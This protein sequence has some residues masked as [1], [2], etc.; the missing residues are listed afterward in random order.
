M[1]AIERADSTPRSVAGLSL[2]VWTDH[3]PG[4][5]RLAAVDRLIAI[6]AEAFWRSARRW[7]V[8]V[9]ADDVAQGIAERAVRDRRREMAGAL[10]RRW[11]VGDDVVEAGGALGRA[12]VDLIGT[13]DESEA[14]AVLVN[15]PG[16]SIDEVMA[17][18]SVLYRLEGPERAAQWLSS[19]P[20]GSAMIDALRASQSVLGELPNGR[21]ALKWMLAVHESPGGFTRWD[22]VLAGWPEEDRSGVRLRH[23]AALATLD[24]SWRF[25]DHDTLAEAVRRRLAGRPTALRGS[26]GEDFA[27]PVDEW[28]A[29]HAARLSRADLLGVWAVLDVLDEPTIVAA[30]FEQA[31]MDR[32]DTST[33]YGGVLWPASDQGAVGRAVLFRPLASEGDRK[34]FSSPELIRAMYHGLAHYHFHAQRHDNAAFAGPGPG[35]LAFARAVGACCVVLTFLD[36]DTLNADVYLPGGEVMDLGMLRRASPGSR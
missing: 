29:A 23:L 32:A 14:L 15:D 1:T 36:A 8:G 18:W 31:E 25:M 20:G 34:F 24:T 2:L 9:S 17:A 11:A 26:R 3:H 6:D 5:V 35:D 21:E 28:T 10:V 22:G 4:E 30:L 12:I 13:R 33:E 16:A 7:L 19:W 27:K